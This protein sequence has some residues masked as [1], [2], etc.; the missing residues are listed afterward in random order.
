MFCGTFEY[1]APEIIRGS[2]YDRSIDIWS[3]GII[4]YEMIN[5]VTPFYVFFI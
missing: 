2:I 5:G 3:L 4:L 1:M